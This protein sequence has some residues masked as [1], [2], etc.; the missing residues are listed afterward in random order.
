MTLIYANEVVEVATME[1]RNGR[2]STLQFSFSRQ[3]GQNLSQN[4]A[5]RFP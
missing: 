2:S 1:V 3:L 4:G 5:N